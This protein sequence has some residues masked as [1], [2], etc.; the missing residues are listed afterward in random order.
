VEKI[1]ESNCSKQDDTNISH[2]LKCQQIIMVFNRT[3][4]KTA[5]RCYDGTEHRRKQQWQKY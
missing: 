2:K 5:W 1:Y 3:T 4:C